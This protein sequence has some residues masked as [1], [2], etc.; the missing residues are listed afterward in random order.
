LSLSGVGL[1]NYCE[2]LASEFGWLEKRGDFFSVN[3]SESVRGAA[4]G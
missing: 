3:G 1:K 2:V 4:L